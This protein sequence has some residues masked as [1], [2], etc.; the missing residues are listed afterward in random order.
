MLATAAGTGTYIR[1]ADLEGD[2]PSIL[3][4]LDAFLAPPESARRFEWLY[5]NN[6]FGVARVFIAC[7]RREDKPVGLSVLFPRRMWLQGSLVR[8]AV[9]G[10]FCVDPAYRTLGPAVQL[11]RASLGPL[12]NGQ[13]VGAYDFPSAAMLAI[14]RRLGVV[15]VHDVVRFIK[16][17]RLR[18]HEA[19]LSRV[20]R[21]A[22]S[23]V[24]SFAVSTMRARTAGLDFAIESSPWGAEYTELAVRCA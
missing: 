14:Y 20:A 9:C 16:P 4:L 1:E 8:A 15:A 17:L 6:P 5:L 10:D 19:S 21:I 22:A 23:C 2:K 12:H 24:A 11:M 13:F 18:T 3:A 7:D